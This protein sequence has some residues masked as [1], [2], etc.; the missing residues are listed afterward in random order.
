MGP[1]WTGDYLNGKVLLGA[2]LE[3]EGRMWAFKDR[4]RSLGAF[5]G[6][7]GRMWAFKDRGRSLGAFLGQGKVPWGLPRNGRTDVG[8]Q[9]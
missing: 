4:G 5:L 2:F 6:T 8:L 9:G 3:T 7:E 1:S